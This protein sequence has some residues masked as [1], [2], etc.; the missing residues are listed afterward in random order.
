MLRLSLSEPLCCRLG[1]TFQ[2]WN[3]YALHDT[4]DVEISGYQ[5]RFLFD[6]RRCCCIFKSQLTSIEMSAV[7]VIS[8]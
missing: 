5:V 8:D 2:Q 6:R 7:S 1:D 4:Y 3:Q